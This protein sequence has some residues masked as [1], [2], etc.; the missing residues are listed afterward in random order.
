MMVTVMGTACPLLACDDPGT[1]RTNLSS[2]IVVSVYFPNLS[3]VQIEKL[4]LREK[5]LPEE[6]IWDPEDPSF[7]Q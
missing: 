1:L 2:F 4:R 3:I 7:S 6:Q 5:G